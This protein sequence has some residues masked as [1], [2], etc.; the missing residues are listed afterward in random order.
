VSR[1]YKQ[2]F[3][4][5]ILAWQTY[6]QDKASFSAT[7]L[8]NYPL[9]TFGVGLRSVIPIQN[10]V[11]VV[12][13]FK[14]A[15]AFNQIHELFAGVNLNYLIIAPSQKLGYGQSRIQPNKPSIYLTAGAAYNRWINYFPSINT[16]AKK[17]NILPEV[18]GGIILGSLTTRVF[19]EGK[20]NPLW[21]ESYSELGIL[22]YPA[23]FKLN[24]KNACPKF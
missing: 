1:I 20:Y 15:P 16:R 5:L 19:I 12:P 23:F 4:L 18:G 2:L 9:S 13:Q 7:A 10:R 3:I 17:D 6:A 11:M 8:Y 24:R 22:F 21:D 14:Y